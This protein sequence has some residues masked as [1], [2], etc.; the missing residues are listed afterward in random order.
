[1]CGFR[2]FTRK[3]KKHYHVLLLLNKNAYD[4]PGDDKK[5]EGNL[6]SMISASW[7]SA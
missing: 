2:E 1:M 6:A 4:H 5:T 7:C 3:G